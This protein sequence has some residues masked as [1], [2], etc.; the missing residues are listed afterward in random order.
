MYVSSC[1]H[2]TDHINRNCGHP[3]AEAKSTDQRRL[4]LTTIN[5]MWHRVVALEG[6]L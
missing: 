2:H 1:S 4:E 5:R 3:T 6:S